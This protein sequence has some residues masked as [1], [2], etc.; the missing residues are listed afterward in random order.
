M[1]EQAAR[2]AQEGARDELQWTKASL[3]LAAS[4]RDSLLR[5]NDKI[6][7]HYKKVGAMHIQ[8]VL[9]SQQRPWQPGEIGHL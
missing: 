6:I 2:E 1:W 4:E 8:S 9:F 5:E 7:L 3:Q